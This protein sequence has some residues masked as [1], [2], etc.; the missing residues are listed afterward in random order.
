MTLKKLCG[1]EGSFIQWVYYI[2]KRL[3]RAR[4]LGKLDTYL[5]IMARHEVMIIHYGVS[6]GFVFSIL[7]QL[8]HDLFN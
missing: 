4:N 5:I 8:A 6:I 3:I 2:F 7:L 1:A